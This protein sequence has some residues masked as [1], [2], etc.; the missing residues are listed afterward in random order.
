MWLSEVNV[1]RCCA[2]ISTLSGT[3]S[4]ELRSRAPR[5]A[6]DLTLADKAEGLNYLKREFKKDATAFRFPTNKDLPYKNTLK[7]TK[8]KQKWSI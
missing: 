1:F 7:K 5:S 8:N 3:H 6:D 4:S 2:I